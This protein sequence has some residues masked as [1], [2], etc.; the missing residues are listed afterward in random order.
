MTVHEE[1]SHLF[2][3]RINRLQLLLASNFGATAH[4]GVSLRKVL[5]LLPNH[6]R[7]REDPPTAASA[8]SHLKRYYVLEKLVELL[9]YPF[10]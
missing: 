10:F 3:W 5:V 8:P 6:D 7:R 2:F 9:W 4:E 1:V